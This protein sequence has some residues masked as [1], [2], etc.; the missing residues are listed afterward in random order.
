[1]RVFMTWLSRISPSEPTGAPQINHLAI[2][3]YVNFIEVPAPVP[4]AA[5]AADPLSANVACEQWPESFAPVVHRLA[6]D[7]DATFEEQ[8]F[9]LPQTSDSASQ[10]LS[11]EELRFI[12]FGAAHAT[13]V[14]AE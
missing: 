7:A 9:H 8:I 3:L 11:S 4:E 1:M 13:V 10:M 5:H 12:R 14:A 6:T 2:Y